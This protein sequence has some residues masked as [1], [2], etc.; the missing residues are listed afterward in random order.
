MVTAELL[1]SLA[2]TLVRS[3]S[4][5]TCTTRQQPQALDLGDLGLV[6]LLP[7][8]GLPPNANS[9]SCNDGD[10]S[11]RQVGPFNPFCNRTIELCWF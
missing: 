9:P 11:G 6:E 1:L 3:R 8:T 5:K 10:P 2:S 4:W 7:G